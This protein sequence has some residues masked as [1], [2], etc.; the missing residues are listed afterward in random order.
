MPE[1]ILLSLGKMYPSSF[2]N[3]DFDYTNARQYDMT[4]VKCARTGAARLKESPPDNELWGDYYYRSDCNFQMID[5]LYDIV[6]SVYDR[7]ECPTSR[8]G[9]IWLDIASNCGVILEAV[10][11]VYTKVGI[12]PVKGEIY[13]RAKQHGTIIQDFFSK[14]VWEKSEFAGRKCK[15][16]TAAAVLY[17][18]PDPQKFIQDCADILDP[19]GVLVLQFSYQPLMMDFN[20]FSD[21]CA[22][23]RYYLNFTDV[24]T[25]LH[26]AGLEAFDVE[27]NAVNCGSIRIYARQFKEDADSINDF[28]ASFKIGGLV[29]LENKWYRGRSAWTRMKEG[30]DL[31]KYDLLDLFREAKANNRK[32][33]GLGASTKA[34]TILQYF[35]I[36]P[37]DLPA[38][39]ETDPKK[40]GLHMI[41]SHIPI[42]SQEEVL[43]QNPDYIIVFVQ[44]YLDSIKEQLKD[45]LAR[46]GKIITLFPE[47]RII[48]E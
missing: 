11:N 7:V 2:V 13:E 6:R 44:Q 39:G 32:V 35:G 12:D 48:S 42:V 14:E 9:D 15:V 21:I 17:D 16:I 19:D 20:S 40:V 36:T 33:L 25:F 22:E 47:V 1:E 27:L 29:E 8:K 5:D 24:S 4:I 18:V 23:H 31:M 37:D 38:I 45:Y 26:N 41:G 28:I 43:A 10:P 3:K 46:G 30:V 34:N